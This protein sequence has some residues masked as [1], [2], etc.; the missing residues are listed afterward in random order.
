MFSVTCRDTHI[1]Q[2][3]RAKDDV[4]ISLSMFTSLDIAGQVKRHKYSRRL[5]TEGWNFTVEKM[6]AKGKR[7]DGGGW[8][9][10]SLPD[11]SSRPLNEVEKMY[12]MCLGQ[13][14][15][16]GITKQTEPNRSVRPVE[17]EQI[18]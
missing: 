11:G 6:G 7:G 18:D 5:P 13:S 4:C 8:K 9:F 3:G 10:V 2:A 15:N 12:G 17:P 16:D 14:P 1:T